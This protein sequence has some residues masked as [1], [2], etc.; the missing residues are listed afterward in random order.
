MAIVGIGVDIVEIERMYKSLASRQNLAKRVLSS[1]ELREFDALSNKEQSM[2]LQARFL[3]KRFA[4]KEAT[5]KAIGTGIA[6]GVGWQQISVAH[7]PSGQP[8][9][10]VSGR[11]AEL[12][13][14]QGVSSCHLSIADEQA[15][16]VANVV[17]EK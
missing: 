8:Y 15:Y 3:A 1:D 14:E 5:V 2:Q 16:A 12:F 11:L 17:L 7:Y 10:E 13:T 9:I 4:A 6:N